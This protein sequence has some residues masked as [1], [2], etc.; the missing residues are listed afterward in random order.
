[1]GT[2]YHLFFHFALDLLF[3]VFQIYG[4]LCGL[5]CLHHAGP[6]MDSV[7]I[8]VIQFPSVLFGNIMLLIIPLLPH[9]DNF[10]FIP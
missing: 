2:E 8:P 3:Q 6:Q 9:A 4:A 10:I 7:E 5:R 1:V